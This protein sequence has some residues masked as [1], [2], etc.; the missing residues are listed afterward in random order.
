MS[1][2]IKI[3]YDPETTICTANVN[4]VEGLLSGNDVNYLI[5]R[6]KELPPGG[7]YVETGSYLG[8]SAILI[9]LHA[10]DPIVYCHDIWVENSEYKNYE[11]VN[12]MPEKEEQYLY[13]F[14][15]NVLDNNLERVIIPMRGDSKYTLEIHKDE[16]IDF[17]FLDG[18]HSREG[19]CA[20][21]STIWPKIKPGGR[22]AFHDKRMEPV[23]EGI[24]D[25]LRNLSDKDTV[26][27]IF[28]IK[29]SNI[30]EFVKKMC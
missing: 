21:I 18:D 13:T 20:D 26:E 2:N 28:D 29:N 12:V 4:G 7:K 14:Y 30:V 6:A 1:I 5:D 8:C 16:S 11:Y 25:F 3:D 19:V 17:A 23:T 24:K 22:V 15:K 9:A 27:D 10:K